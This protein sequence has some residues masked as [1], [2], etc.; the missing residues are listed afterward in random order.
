[1][2]TKISS[3][4][5]EGVKNLLFLVVII[6]LLLPG[7]QGRFKI[8]KEPVLEGAYKQAEAPSI[9]SLSV[10]SWFNGHFQEEY[11][12]RL[13]QNIGFRSLLVKFNNQIDFSLFDK[14]NAE[15][16]VVGK[17]NMLFEE[18]YIKEYLG[19]YY[20]GDSV[21]INKA[22]RLK[23]VQDT[24]NKIGKTLLVIFEPD[25]ASVY[26]EN[27]PN[28]YNLNSK[29]TSNYERLSAELMANH[30]NV[31]DLNKY[32][33]SI[34]GKTE[35]PIF[36]QCG[37][38]WSYYGATFAADT[39]I[40]FIEKLMNVDLPEM[41]IVRNIALD[42]PRHPDYDI[43]LAMNLF[44]MIPH[45][46]TAD[47]VLDFSNN[48]SK[49]KPNAL[50]VGDSFYFNWL[51]NGIPKNIF[52]TCDFWYYN[53][54]ITHNDGVQDGKAADLN[55]K[56]EIMKRDIIIIMITGR[57]M[58]AFAWGF[59]NQLYDIFFPGKIAPVEHFA[60]ALRVYGNEFKRL[61]KESLEKGITVNERIYME[62]DYLFYE[63]MKNHPEKYSDKESLIKS[64]EISIR[65][66]PEWMKDIE[67]K[68]K[69]NKVSVDKQVRMDAEW[70][71]QDKM[72]KQ[73]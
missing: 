52:S 19:M 32:F 38:H 14:A 42:V 33:Q 55:F 17:E 35:Y 22:I 1:M 47:P 20:V 65:S 16:V 43:G 27:I 70:L 37:T 29:K 53:N 58:H 24:L 57:F 49:K 2:N 7:I 48:S 71:Y 46:K 26:P 59:D 60:D 63:D 41:K 18:D 50:V 61:Y 4:R 39:S 64:Y 45:P 44:F 51:N 73:Q 54:N 21:W 72:K 28:L 67:R 69:L 68:A 11:D 5:Q 62:A 6:L 56:D 10:D 34:K 25:K 36:P 30:I 31:L 9:D 13:E 66:T 12:Q 23:Q 40:R 8:V 15:G 3:N